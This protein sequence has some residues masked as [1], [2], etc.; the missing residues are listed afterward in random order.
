MESV[1]LYVKEVQY[2]YR[3][4]STA[5]SILE[6][7]WIVASWLITAPTPAASSAVNTVAPLPPRDVIK[8]QDNLT[9]TRIER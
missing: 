4:Q 2:G 5:H 7:A 8:M 6:R 9:H 3:L 1:W